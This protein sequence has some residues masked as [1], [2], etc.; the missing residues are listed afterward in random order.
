MIPVCPKCD[1]QLIIARFRDVEVDVC[2][3]CSGIWMDRGEIAEL[4]RQTGATPDDSIIRST[5]A[6]GR[7]ARGKKNLCPR[8][9]ALLLEIEIRCPQPGAEQP[10]IILERC[11]HRHGIWFDK[12]EMEQLLGFFPPSCGAGKTIDYLHEFFGTKIEKETPTGGI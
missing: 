2:P 8:C 4:M 5:E 1:I 11:P 6:K 3:S 9:D 7:H 12:G 10:P